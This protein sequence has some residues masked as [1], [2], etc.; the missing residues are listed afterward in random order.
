MAMLCQFRHTELAG[1]PTCEQ[2]RESGK[3]LKKQT[4]NGLQ[5]M[6]HL[7]A[8]AVDKSEEV[9]TMY[10]ERLSLQVEKHTLFLQKEQIMVRY[11]SLNEQTTM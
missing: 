2:Q 11:T 4:R 3:C 1:S 8:E 9:W 10:E 5:L 6:L 7:P